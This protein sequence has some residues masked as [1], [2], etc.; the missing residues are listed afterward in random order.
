MNKK[1]SNV[2]CCESYMV[3]L[4]KPFSNKNNEDDDNKKK[5]PIDPK[6]VFVGY[7]KINSKSKKNSY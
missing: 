5:K 1:Y 7:K 6:K 4:N 2:N 3:E